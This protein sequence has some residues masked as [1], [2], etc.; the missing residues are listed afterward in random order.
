MDFTIF[1]IVTFF[2]YLIVCFYMAYRNTWVYNV[3]IKAIG[4]ALHDELIS[5]DEMMYNHVFT[6]DINKMKKSNL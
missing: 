2:L 5:Y 3:R 4:S 6:Y 1:Y